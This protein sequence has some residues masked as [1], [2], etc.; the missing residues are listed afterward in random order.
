MRSNN[1]TNAQTTHPIDVVAFSA[2]QIG[3][4]VLRVTLTALLKHRDEFR[5][6]KFNEYND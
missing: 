1:D 5:F 3:R 6:T 2:K 4:I